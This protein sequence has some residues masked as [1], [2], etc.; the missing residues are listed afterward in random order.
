M[1]YTKYWIQNVWCYCLFSTK[2]EQ[3]L[4]SCYWLMSRRQDL[5]ILNSVCVEFINSIFIVQWIML[6]ML[7]CRGDV[8]L[9]KCKGFAFFLMAFEASYSS[10]YNFDWVFQVETFNVCRFV[11]LNEY[12]C[13]VTFHDF[14]KIFS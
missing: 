10:Y 12:K 6:G 3:H 9:L 11:E 13:N 8:R 7:M 14:F 2:L 4:Y 5:P 1:H